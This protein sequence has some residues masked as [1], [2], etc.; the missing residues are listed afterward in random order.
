MLR[1]V[2]VEFHNRPGALEGHCKLGFTVLLAG[3][4]KLD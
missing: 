4:D 3:C 2:D 1:I